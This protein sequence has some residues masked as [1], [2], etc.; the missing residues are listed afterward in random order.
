M[1]LGQQEDTGHKQP[2]PLEYET[3]SDNELKVTKKVTLA[4]KKFVA[5]HASPG[6]EDEYEIMTGGSGCT[7]MVIRL[8]LIF[9]YSKNRLIGVLIAISYPFLL[10]RYDIISIFSAT[11]KRY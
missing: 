4:M 1:K 8:N 9:T 10:L 2:V 7:L 11:N 3:D 5:G 6:R